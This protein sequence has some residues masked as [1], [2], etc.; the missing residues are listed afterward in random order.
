M[1]H[2][3]DISVLKIAFQMCS[4][5]VINTCIVISTC[6]CVGRHGVGLYF[7]VETNTYDILSIYH[8]PGNFH[9][10]KPFANFATYS[11]WRNLFYHEYFCNTKV[12]KVIRLGEII[13]QRKISAIRYNM[14][15][16]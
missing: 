14:H 3:Y 9:Q 13:V 7:D 1:Q 5:F 8:I 12:T 11:R 4:S 10:E 15:Q 16:T 6:T 2:V